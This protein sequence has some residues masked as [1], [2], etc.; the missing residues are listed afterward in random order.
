MTPQEFKRQMDRLASTY[1]PKSYPQERADLLWQEFK[2]LS[3]VTYEKVISR[4]IGE[5]SAPPMLPKFREAAAI[6]REH[7]AVREKEEYR[8]GTQAALQSTTLK[9]FIRRTIDSGNTHDLDGLVQ[10]FGL[11]WVERKY[12]QAKRDAA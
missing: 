6:M 9:D 4:L 1:G 7:H 10:L 11:E 3:G 5:N 8:Q 12:Q 2:H